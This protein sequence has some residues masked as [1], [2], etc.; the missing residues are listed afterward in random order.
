MTG[1]FLVGGKRAMVRMLA[2]E[3]LPINGMYAEYGTDKKLVATPKSFDYFSRLLSDDDPSKGFARI[4][5]TGREVDEL[6][7]SI[8]FT[9]ML[10][11]SDFSM[12]TPPPG[13]MI[14]AVTLC[15]MKNS[16]AIDDILIY[17]MIL[18]NPVKII[19]G[20]L[21]TIRTTLSFGVTN[22]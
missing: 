14:N 6:T 13:S 15:H 18:P 3:S 16:D 9:G 5:V 4:A 10:V 1:M 7:A 2:G 22:G 21:T 12:K 20:A 17:T 19:D 11:N 8:T